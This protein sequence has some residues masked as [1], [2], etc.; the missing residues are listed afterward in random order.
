MAVFSIGA[1][2]I[3]I[4]RD[5]IR[6]VVTATENRRWWSVNSGESRDA[7]RLSKEEEFKS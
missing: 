5:S 4:V 1:F 6:G 2:P 3:D 7:G